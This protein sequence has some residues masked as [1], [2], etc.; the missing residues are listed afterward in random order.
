M[1]RWLTVIATLVM[2]SVN[3]LA[4]ALPI[5]GK[6]TGDIADGF[7]ILF[8]PAGYVFSIWGLIYFGVLGFTVVQALPSRQA[9][10][11]I[12]AI[13]PWFLLNALGNATWIVV[14]HHER[15]VLSWFVMLVI[16]GSLIAIY[17]KLIA[18]PA[19]GVLESLFV[20]APFRI[21]LGWISVA[22]IANTTVV[23]SSLGF[24]SLLADL[25]VTL[26]IMVAATA[27]CLVVSLRFRDPL[28]AAV[29]VW[30]EVG[31]AA[32]NPDQPMLRV[33]AY[34]LA[35]VCAAAGLRSGLA[36]FRQSGRRQT[37]LTP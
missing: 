4:N 20:Q 17:T 32:A 26:G 22:T 16:L 31:I 12:I 25:T 15:F 9:N 14:W 1:L 29:F 18:R 33:A 2:I 11:T 36:L 24:E 10:A 7:D 27:I 5:N 21:Y 13:R 3:G 8:T 28:Y 30:A 23:L 6:T 19:E 35:G 37:G 34:I